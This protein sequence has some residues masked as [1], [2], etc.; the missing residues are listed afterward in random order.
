MRAV[1]LFLVT[2]F[3]VLELV[4]MIWIFFKL[5]T[6]KVDYNRNEFKFKV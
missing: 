5:I 2:L 4:F 6:A 3:K 1:N